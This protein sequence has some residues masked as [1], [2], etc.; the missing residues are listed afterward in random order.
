VAPRF[1]TKREVVGLDDVV[2]AKNRTRINDILAAQ[3]GSKVEAIDLFFDIEGVDTLSNFD[4][5]E[6]SNLDTLAA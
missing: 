5:I 2:S 3:Y 4:Y 6:V 1:N